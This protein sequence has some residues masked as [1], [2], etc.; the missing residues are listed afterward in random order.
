MPIRSVQ[1]VAVLVGYSHMNSR[2]RSPC[3]PLSV[4]A[5][6]IMQRAF[7]RSSGGLR[8]LLLRLVFDST[9]ASET[10]GGGAESGAELEAGDSE[11]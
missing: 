10:R 7:V 8:K 4:I 2:Q 3:E 5:S 1:A 9:L 6:C 11:R